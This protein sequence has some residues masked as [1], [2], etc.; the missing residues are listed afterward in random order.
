M[1]N[2]KKAQA[3]AERMTKRH[4][5]HTWATN[6][7]N[8]VEERRAYERKSK[9]RQDLLEQEWAEAK[10]EEDEAR[11]QREAEEAARLAEEERK[12]REQEDYEQWWEQEKLRAYERGVNRK[13]MAIQEKEWKAEKEAR[14]RAEA[15]EKEKMWRT[16]EDAAAE[17]SMQEAID[18][19]LT[20]EGRKVLDWE[21][22]KLRMQSTTRWDGKDG[23]TG[24]MDGDWVKMYDDEIHEVFYYNHKTGGRVTADTLSLEEARNIARKEWID[25]FM[26]QA[27][28]DVRILQREKLQEELEYKSA[29]TLQGIARCHRARKELRRRCREVIVKRVVPTST[30]LSEVYVAMVAMIPS[31]HDTRCPRALPPPHWTDCVHVFHRVHAPGRSVPRYYYDTRLT[32]GRPSWTKPLV[33]GPEEDIHL[34]EWVYLQDPNGTPYYQQTVA[35]RATSWEKPPG[36]V[37][38]MQCNLEFGRRRCR[39]CTWIYCFECFA[40]AHKRGLK[41]HVWLKMDVKAQMCLMCKDTVATKLCAECDFDPYCDHCFELFHFHGSKALSHDRETHSTLVHLT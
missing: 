30:D 37:L 3:F 10:R 9:M 32:D 24:G 38:C 36:Y 19:L 41:E 28:E 2:E 21:V 34:D 17:R 1:L 18:Y 35:P 23:D 22:K 15:E 13:K 14:R 25:K 5:L 29:F 39:G 20:G 11:A 33:L 6:V 26:L 27:R 31:V 8:I 40:A 4:W 16:I 7:H 12:R